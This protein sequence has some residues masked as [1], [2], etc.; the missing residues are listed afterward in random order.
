M[1]RETVLEWR[2]VKDGGKGGC[3]SVHMRKAGRKVKSVRERW[4]ETRVKE[5][6]HRQNRRKGVRGVKVEQ[7][8][9]LR[10]GSRI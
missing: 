8:V 7:G 5:E 1:D 9:G 6:G 10:G 4:R 2:L 3:S